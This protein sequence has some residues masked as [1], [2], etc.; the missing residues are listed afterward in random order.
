MS[1]NSKKEQKSTGILYVV[2]RWIVWTVAALVALN[3]AVTGF[4]VG[5]GSGGVP[6]LRDHLAEAQEQ[7]NQLA[8]HDIAY[9]NK[10]LNLTDELV[11][12]NSCSCD[13]DQFEGEAKIFNLDG[14]PK[15]KNN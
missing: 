13:E 5:W 7:R 2:P 12:M 15:A 10:V 8:R 1:E 3:G 14:T 9:A 6:D 4:I 11:A